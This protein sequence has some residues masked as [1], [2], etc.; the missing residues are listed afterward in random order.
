MFSQVIRV[1]HV[2]ISIWEKSSTNVSARSSGQDIAI[3]VSIQ[4][5]SFSCCTPFQMAYSYLN[6][7]WLFLVKGLLRLETSIKRNPLELNAQETLRK[8]WKYRLYSLA[9]TV[10]ANPS[11]VHFLSLDFYASVN[12]NV[13]YL[14][15]LSYL[16]SC[17][18]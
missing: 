5:P 17:F 18:M 2:K 8:S 9:L 10:D 7:S 1:V 13:T 12:M 11:L 15:C 3:F 4:P 16:E 14:P 6:D